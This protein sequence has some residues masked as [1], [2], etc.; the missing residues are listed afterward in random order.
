[1]STTIMEHSQS[2]YVPTAHAVH[3]SRHGVM[4]HRK[5]Q[6]TGGGRAWSVA[7]VSNSSYLV[8]SDLN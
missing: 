4:K 8:S 1:M 6:S 7:E 3:S 5:S 2:V